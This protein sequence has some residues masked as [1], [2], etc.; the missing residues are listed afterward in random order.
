M[1]VSGAP[2]LNQPG[3]T[4]VVATRSRLGHSNG[5]TTALRNIA[6]KG[7]PLIVRTTQA[8]NAIAAGLRAAAKADHVRSDVHRIST[9]AGRIGPAFRLRPYESVHGGRSPSA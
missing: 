4:F 3:G 1:R 2:Q 6:T 9:V 8:L 7:P 5:R